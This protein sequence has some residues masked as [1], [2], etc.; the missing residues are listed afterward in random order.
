MSTTQQEFRCT[1]PDPYD[2]KRSSWELGFKPRASGHIID[3]HVRNPTEPWGDIL[4]PDQY[5]RLK[6]LPGS[7]RK[8]DDHRRLKSLLLALAHQSCKRPQVITFQEQELAAGNAA[9]ASFPV[10]CA[11]LVCHCGLLIAVRQEPGANQAEHKIATAFFRHDSLSRARGKPSWTKV[12]AELIRDYCPTGDGGR[13]LYPT[14]E[15]VQVVGDE[16][17]PD[18]KRQ[19]S[20][21][22]FLSLHTWNFQTVNGQTIHRFSYPDWNPG[23]LPTIVAE[24]VDGAGK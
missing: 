8:D 14:P 12:A 13:V 24:Q 2:R 1:V 19:R 23:P 17:R 6:S 18:C 16:D 3:K 10:S 20:H 9:S 22:E 21:I 4:S 15:V 11:L 5:Q 7:A